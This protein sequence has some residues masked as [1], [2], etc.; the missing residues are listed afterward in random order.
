MKVSN[1]TGIGKFRQ[2]QKMTGIRKFRQ[3]QKM[4]SIKLGITLF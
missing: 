3:L 4:I 1:P 2:L